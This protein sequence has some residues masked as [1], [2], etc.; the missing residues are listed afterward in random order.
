M[1]ENVAKSENKEKDVGNKRQ[2]LGLPSVTSVTT[3]GL[4]LVAHIYMYIA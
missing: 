2:I 1:E 4:R 3:K